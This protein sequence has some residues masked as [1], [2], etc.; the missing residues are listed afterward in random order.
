MLCWRQHPLIYLKILVWNYLIN[1]AVIETKAG[2]NKYLK[3]QVKVAKAKM[4]RQRDIPNL[5]SYYFMYFEL[6]FTGLE[7]EFGY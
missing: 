3:R 1:T 7:T 2:I 4:E 5:G 6:K